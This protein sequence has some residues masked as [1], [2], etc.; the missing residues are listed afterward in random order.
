M[1]TPESKP[2]TP[3]NRLLAA[4][5]EDL[6][7]SGLS[8][9]TIAA[10]G[11]YSAS[12]KETKAILGFD[13]GPGIAV[14]YVGTAPLLVR[15]K[16]DEPF[17]GKDGKAAKYLSPLKRLYSAGNRLY[18]PAT[19]HPLVPTDP[20]VD[21]IVT[22][23]EK[24]ALKAVQEGFPTVALAGVTC[25]RT[26]LPDGT[27]RAIADLDLIKWNGRRVFICFDSDVMT[28]AAVRNQMLKLRGELSRRRA[29]VFAAT[30][31]ELPDQEGTK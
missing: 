3:S 5:L 31:P 7:R 29:I 12:A 21:L 22:E 10:S 8:D 20:G 30:L 4:H 24:K 15:I 27:S 14:P 17:A 28:K 25:W 1:G 2:T 19:L 11:I 9:E 18:L 26:K 13:S 6:R 16:P 23:G